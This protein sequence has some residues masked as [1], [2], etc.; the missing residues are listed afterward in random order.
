MC[1]FANQTLQKNKTKYISHVQIKYFLSLH[2]LNRHASPDLGTPD[3]IV[4]TRRTPNFAP[5]IQK[6]ATSPF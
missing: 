3:K 4:S 6:P 1:V 2:K 5:R